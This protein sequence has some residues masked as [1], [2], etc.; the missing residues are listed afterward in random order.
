METIQLFNKHDKNNTGKID[1]I[2][3]K[4]VFESINMEVKSEYVEYIFYLMKQ[5][6]EET[7]TQEIYENLGLE[8]FNYKVFRIKLTVSTFRT[9]LRLFLMP[10]LMIQKYPFQ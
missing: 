5:P 9:L 6:T 4:R 7:E 8:E 3:L 1:F 2:T 10:T